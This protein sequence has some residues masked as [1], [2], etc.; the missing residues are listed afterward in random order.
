M[1]NYE[2]YFGTPNE[3]NERANDHRTCVM[4]LVGYEC[5]ERSVN[6]CPFFRNYDCYKSQLEWL[7]EES[8]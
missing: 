1:N 6:R 2:R 5:N 3:L 8:E 4:R 7:E